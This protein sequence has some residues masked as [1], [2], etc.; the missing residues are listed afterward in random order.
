MTLL[1]IRDLTLTIGTTDI[2]H[3]VDVQLQRGEIV[4]ITGES[5]SGKSMTA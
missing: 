3:N 4:A 5:G 2:L 1:H